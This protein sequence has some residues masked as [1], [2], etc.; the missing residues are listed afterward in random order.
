[1][2]GLRYKTLISE[3]RVSWTK[4]NRFI[5]RFP[6]SV[7]WSNTN[8]TFFEIQKPKGGTLCP[9]AKTL[10][11]FSET[12]QIKIFWKLVQKWIFWQTLVSMETMISVFLVVHTFRF[13]TGNPV[14][15]QKSKTLLPEWHHSWSNGIRLP[16][17]RSLKHE[18]SA[19]K[20]SQGRNEAEDQDQISTLDYIWDILHGNRKNS[21]SSGEL[22][23]E[24]CQNVFFKNMRKLRTLPW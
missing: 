4:Q 14:P 17:L 2:K 18:K 8:Q 12:S 15:F 16:N 7:A 19:K 20:L 9:L 1:M 23:H 24:N 5:F 10:L 3:E 13:L 21:F 6:F 11:P 22:L